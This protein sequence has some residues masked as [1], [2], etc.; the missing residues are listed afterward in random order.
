[1]FKPDEVARAFDQLVDWVDMGKRPAP[2]AVPAQAGA[3]TKETIR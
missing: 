3:Q 2:G 1:V